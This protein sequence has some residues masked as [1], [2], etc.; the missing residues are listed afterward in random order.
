MKNTPQ[1]VWGVRNPPYIYK[2]LEPVGFRRLR[3]WGGGWA[4]VLADF[5]PPKRGCGRL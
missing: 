1:G 2:S 5:S 4:L 3:L